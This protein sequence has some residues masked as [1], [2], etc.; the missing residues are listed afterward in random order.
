MKARAVINLT[1]SQSVGARSSPARHEP[2]TLP[3]RPHLSHSLDTAML[4]PSLFTR[5]RRG[6]HGLIF[7]P[8]DGHVRLLVVARHCFLSSFG[9]KMIRID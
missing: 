2:A 3:I 8:W 9:F 1:P 5:T 7:A 4:K 6:G